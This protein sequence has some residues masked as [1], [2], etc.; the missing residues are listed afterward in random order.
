MPLHRLNA[1]LGRLGLGAD[2]PRRHRPAD[3][4]RGALDRHARHR[5][6]LRRPGHAGARA[7][8]WCWRRLGARLLAHRARR[9]VFAAARIGLGALGVLSTV[10]LQAE[11]AFALR[12]EEGPAPLAGALEGFD[13][14]M[15]SA[16][17]V[18][19]YWFPHT[20]RCLT[21]RNTRVPL[22][23]GSRRCARWRAVW[24]DEIL[25]NAVFGGRGRR[26]SPGPGTGAAAGPD[27]GAGARAPAPGPTTRT[28]SSSAGGGSASRRWSTPSRGPTPRR[29]SPSSRRVHEA[30]DWRRRLPG[31]GPGGRGRRHPAVDG[32]RPRDRLHRRARARGNATRGRGS[33]PSR[34]SRARSAAG[35]TGASCTAWTP[36][37]AASAIRG[38]TS[39]SP[40]ATGSTRPGC[41]ATPTSTACWAPR[42]A[43]GRAGR[44]CSGK[45]PLETG[46]GWISTLT[47]PSFFSRKFM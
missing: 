20:D 1:E 33:P 8:S 34:R 25:A 15:T 26:R 28:R 7:S 38:S 18:E 40:C 31:R 46:Q 19:F 30:S 2:Q 27:L 23:R 3:G 12:A 41:S 36:T 16:D 43:A 39:S 21:K 35:R 14:F 42:P 4:R 37:A 13:E 6:P 45:G 29:S 11:P 47:V 5:R 44:G 10:T 32:E 22:E 24:D 17:H 9:S